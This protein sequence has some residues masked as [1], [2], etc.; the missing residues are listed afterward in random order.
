[1]NLASSSACSVDDSGGGD[2]SANGGGGVLVL[3]ARSRRETLLWAKVLQV[4]LFIGVTIFGARPPAKNQVPPEGPLN[5]SDGKFYWLGGE[6][7]HRIRCARSPRWRCLSH[8]GNAVQMCLNLAGVRHC[9]IWSMDWC[10]L[11][12]YS[13]SRDHLSFISISCV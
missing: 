7:C 1:M 4:L 2:G 5:T 8:V 3:Q 13:A 9:V 10:H 12:K 11:K 6:G